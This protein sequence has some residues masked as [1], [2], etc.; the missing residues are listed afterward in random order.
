MQ[1][2]TLWTLCNTSIDMP[3]LK[4]GINRLIPSVIWQPKSQVMVTFRELP[5]NGVILDI[6]AGGRQIAPNVI[7]VDFILY[8]NTRVVSDIHSLSFA[9][10]SV[11][12]I[13]CTGTL[14]HIDNPIQALNEIHRILKPQGIL[15]IEV[16]FMQPF[17]KDPEDYW[18]WTLD[19]IKLLASQNGFNELRSGPLIGSASAMNAI[20]VAYFQSWF[21]NRYIRKLI[22]MIL[23]CCL[24]P[25]K[26]LDI[27]LIKR[28]QD[29]LSA[30]YY[31]GIKSQKSHRE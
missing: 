13:F 12:T 31:V 5:H 30:C 4:K 25:F 21:F 9:N 17:H 22:D 16:P 18:R 2:I 19:G 27:I 20:I 8:K 24:F 6:G 28:S 26:F 15:H 23:S 10:E 3:W 29:L 14:E 1:Y 11:D 7:G